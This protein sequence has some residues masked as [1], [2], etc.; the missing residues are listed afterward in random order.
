MGILNNTNNP[1]HEV[2]L[3]RKS[4]EPLE[5]QLSI[6]RR[7]FKDTRYTPNISQDKEV[8]KFNRMAEKLFGYESFSLTISSAQY[9]N[10]YTLPLAMYATKDEKKKLKQA[11]IANPAGF[12]YSP[13]A[14]AVAIST[15]CFGLINSDN[16]TDEEIFAVWLHEIGHT[17]FES[18]SD[19]DCVLS[20]SATLLDILDK[21]NLNINYAIDNGHTLDDVKY[22][23]NGLRNTIRKVFE[24]NK[25]NNL[26]SNLYNI[27]TKPFNPIKNRIGK[28]F[29]HEGMKDNLRADRVDY[30]NEKFAD[31]FAAIYGY[32]V[33]LHSGLLKMMTNYGDNYKEANDSISVS[34]GVFTRNINDI[35]E[36]VYN[37]K[38]EH[39][40][41]LTRI[42][43]STDYLKRE[44]AREGIDPKLKREMIG[45][46]ERLNI[47]IDEY[48]S[49]PR[50]KDNIAITRAFYTMLYNEFG[51]DRREQ[52]TDNNALFDNT[53]SRYRDLRRK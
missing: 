39:P 53:D 41:G 52:D 22:D 43:T 47:L 13:N 33:P 42:K 1:L 26:F 23:I 37:V 27:I 5:R 7:K 51:G 18:V 14:H 21:A 17:F 16:I 30:T 36:Y 35:M 15:L 48:V 6:I 34:V 40:D 49:V 9:I 45:Q 44:I 19:K 4:V 25:I 50:D 12:K 3:G 32:G 11:L 10:A 2:Y 20:L 24:F 31:T 46:L 28:F 8:I 29:K 38:D